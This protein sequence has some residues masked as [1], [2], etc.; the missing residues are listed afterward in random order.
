MA[1]AAWATLALYADGDPLRSGVPN[2]DL[3]ARANLA[4]A[5][6]ADLVRLDPL[7]RRRELG[8]A[9]GTETFAAHDDALGQRLSGIVQQEVVAEAGLP[10]RGAKTTDFYVIRWAN[11]PARPRRGRLHLEPPPS[12]C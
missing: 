9:N 8:A 11:M 7:Q 5:A 6:G 3:Q 10:D 12:A 4:N 1:L 2:D